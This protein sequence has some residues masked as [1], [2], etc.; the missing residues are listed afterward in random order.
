MNQSKEIS[1]LK[2]GTPGKSPTGP[3]LQCV[4]KNEKMQPLRR[5]PPSF[6]HPVLLPPPG[7]KPPCIHGQEDNNLKGGSLKEIQL[8]ASLRRS[9]ARWWLL[10]KAQP[11][12]ALGGEGEGSWKWDSWS[13][14]PTREAS[15][16]AS[17]TPRHKARIHAVTWAGKQSTFIT[18]STAHHLQTAA[19]C[20]R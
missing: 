6:L 11:V 19:L 18:E 10:E 17:P 15:P 1:A 13:L 9:L 20:L 16:A 7:H 3:G 8:S 2:T 4:G 12:L 5:F 14:P